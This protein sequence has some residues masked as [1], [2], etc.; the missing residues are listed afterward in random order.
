MKRNNKD[1]MC[2]EET[3]NKRNELSFV[4]RCSGKDPF[5]K[6]YKVYVK[7]VKVPLDLKGK[8]EIEQFRLQCQIDWKNEVDKKSKGLLLYKDD[9]TCFYDY[10][11]KWVEDII[12]YNKEAYH[13]YSTCKGNLKIFKEKFGLYT[14]QEM[15]LPVIQHF[16]DWLC[17]RTYKKEIIRVKKSIKEIIQEKHLTFK[18]TYTGCG[19]ANATLCVALEV[20]KTINKTTAKKI[21]DFLDIN[22]NTYFELTS[23]DIPYSK[24]S[25]K[26]LKGMLHSVLS[27]AVKEGLIPINYATNEYTKPVT[28]TVGKKEIFDSLD[29]IREFRNIINDEQDIRKKT[30]FFISLN[31]GVRSA[32]LAGLEWKDIDFETG[33]LSINRNTMYVSGFGTVTKGTKN[34]SSTRTIK[35]PMGLI[36]ILKEY[37]TWWEQEKIYHGDLWANTDRLFVQH[38]GKDMANST[39]SKWL[40]KFEE[41]KNIKH[42]TL[43]GL[44]HTNITMLITNG[45]DVKTVS[46][47]VG[48]N[49]PQ[50]TLKIYSHYTKESDSKASELI[51]NLIFG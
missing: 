42:V 12:R 45:T 8:K 25:N 33:I 51:D 43:H 23:E 34:K 16:C 10:A 48:H 39:I 11:E 27:Q 28:G 35:M 5:T 37:K 19:I 14:L 31:T 49:N 40:S 9:K 46:A 36:S 32:E 44:R 1:I 29:E 50:T 22:F 2:V 24:S 13:H 47:R 30:A 38:C 15:T 6:K 20:G 41:L 26:S 7:T 18:Q 17:E 21:C 3:Y 4:L